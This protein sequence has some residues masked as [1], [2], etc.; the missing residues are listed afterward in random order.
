MCRGCAPGWRRAPENGV[1]LA[2]VYGLGYR[3]E[4]LSADDGAA[5]PCPLAGAAE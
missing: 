5:L 2:S 3:P 1:V 4:F